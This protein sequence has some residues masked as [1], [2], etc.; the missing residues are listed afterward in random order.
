MEFTK[1]KYWLVGW[2]KYVKRLGNKMTED[3]YWNFLINGSIIHNVLRE[4]MWKHTNLSKKN[5]DI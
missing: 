1:I 2:E 5:A 4:S 3:K